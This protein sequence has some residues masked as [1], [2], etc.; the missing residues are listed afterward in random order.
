M[1]SIHDIA[2]VP[3]ELRD[4][5]NDDGFDLARYAYGLDIDTSGSSYPSA[6]A[7]EV[8]EIPTCPSAPEIDEI[9]TSPSAPPD[10]VF[11]DHQVR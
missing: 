7:P 6:P 5:T 1:A 3:Q 2:G 9:S 11:D 10:D 4:A 8:D